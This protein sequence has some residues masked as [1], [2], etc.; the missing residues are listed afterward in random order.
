LSK[1]LANLPIKLLK[2]W[3]TKHSVLI[4]VSKL[5][6]LSVINECSVQLYKDTGVINEMHIMILLYSARVPKRKIITSSINYYYLCLISYFCASLDPIIFFFKLRIYIWFYL[7]WQPL[8]PNTYSLRSK[9]KKK[10]KD[11]FHNNS[12]STY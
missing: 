3:S 6:N 8:H 11:L 9:N 10:S 5:D 2:F 1:F 7:I 4:K 12:N